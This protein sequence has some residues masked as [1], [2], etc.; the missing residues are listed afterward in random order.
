MSSKSKSKVR[1]P[2]QAIRCEGLCV[3]P[4]HSRQG[5]PSGTTTG[6][7][8]HET[9]RAQFAGKRSAT[10][11]AERAG[12]QH[13]D[14]DFDLEE[15]YRNTKKQ[16]K[17]DLLN[18]CYLGT[19]LPKMLQQSNR[20]RDHDPAAPEVRVARDGSLTITGDECGD[21]FNYH[22]VTYKAPEGVLRAISSDKWRNLRVCAYQYATR[23]SIDIHDHLDVDEISVDMIASAIAQR[24]TG[25][26]PDDF[27]STTAQRWVI[28]Q[29]SRPAP[30]QSNNANANPDN[31][32]VAPVSA[33]G[34]GDS[35][36][37]LTPSL[38]ISPPTDLRAQAID[39]LVACA[40]IML[41]SCLVELE[42]VQQ[43]RIA[44]ALEDLR[45]ERL[46]ARYNTCVHLVTNATLDQHAYEQ[47]RSTLTSHLKTWLHINSP[48]A[49]EALLTTL[50]S[51]RSDDD[52]LRTA[53]LGRLQLFARAFCLVGSAL[54][55]IEMSEQRLLSSNVDLLD[56]VGVVAGAANIQPNVPITLHT[57]AH[58]S[59][60][61]APFAATNPP[62]AVEPTTHR[63]TA[64]VYIDCNEDDSAEDEPAPRGDVAYSL[65]AFS[66]GR[67]VPQCDSACSD[68]TEPQPEVR[69]GYWSGTHREAL[70]VHTDLPKGADSSVPTKPDPIYIG[71]EECR[72]S[73]PPTKVSVENSLFAGCSVRTT[74][75]DPTNQAFFHT[76]IEPSID[77]TY[78]AMCGIGIREYDPDSK[79]ASVHQAIVTIDVLRCRDIKLID[80]F[81][82]NLNNND[83]IAHSLRHIHWHLPIRN[84]A[85][86]I[87]TS[88]RSNITHVT[89][90]IAPIL[91]P[92]AGIWN[93]L[94]SVDDVYA[95]QLPRSD[96]L[97]TTLAEAID[98]DTHMVAIHDLCVLQS[99][100]TY[101]TTHRVM[102]YYPPQMLGHSV[103]H[104]TTVVYELPEEVIDFIAGAYR[105]HIETRNATFTRP[106]LEEV[107]PGHFV[108]GRIGHD[109]MVAVHHKDS[110][111]LGKHLLRRWPFQL[112]QRWTGN[113]CACTRLI[114]LRWNAVL[115]PHES[116]QPHRLRPELRQFTNQFFSAHSDE[117]VIN[118]RLSA[119]CNAANEQQITTTATERKEIKEIL[120][121]EARELENT[122]ATTL[123]RP[124]DYYGNHVTMERVRLLNRVAGRCEA[125]CVT[126]RGRSHECGHNHNCPFGHGPLMRELQ[127]GERVE[128]C[129]V[130]HNVMRIVDIIYT[131]EWELSAVVEGTFPVRAFGVPHR[132]ANKKG[133]VA[134]A[135]RL[136][137]HGP[138]VTL[139]LFPYVPKPRYGPFL[140]G[141]AFVQISPFAT[142]IYPPTM[143]SMLRA[144]MLSEQ[145]R[146]ARFAIDFVVAHTHTIA[147]PKE[148]RPLSRDAWI[149]RFDG[150]KRRM[151]IE[152]MKTFD[153]APA[154][155]RK[156]LTR[157]IFKKEEKLVKSK[158]DQYAGRG[159]SSA[160]PRVQC[161]TGPWF[162]AFNTAL[163]K[164]WPLHGSKISFVCGYDAVAV[165]AM[166]TE[167]EGDGYSYIWDG[168]YSSFDASENM[169]LLRDVEQLVYR[170]SGIGDRNFWRC[171]EA[172]LDTKALVFLGR[173]VIAKFR[174]EGRRNSG[175]A[176][177]TIGNSLINALV[178]SSIL[179]FW[180]YDYRLAVSGD[181]CAI[182]FRGRHPRWE[183]VRDHAADCGLKLKIFPRTHYHDVHFLGSHPL[184]MEVDGRVQYV[185]VPEMVRVLPKFGWSLSPMLQPQVW[186]R[187]VAK[188]WQMVGSHVPILRSLIARTLQLTE[189]F[190]VM[191]LDPRDIPQFLRVESQ[192]R[193][194]LTHQGAQQFSMRYSLTLDAIARIE[195]LVMVSS[196]PSIVSTTLLNHV[197]VPE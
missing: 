127:N 50:P 105:T 122:H 100:H 27:D 163:K 191:K 183:D 130:C 137:G 169:W 9:N 34:A 91:L 86:A 87:F 185:M 45:R 134:T 167:W 112:K 110:C 188:S 177:T 144:R 64:L 121:M 152:A 106:Q 19:T 180:R 41:G 6:V 103:A 46:D 43:Q 25:I 189:G 113:S 30:Q 53:A 115:G 99:R 107:V 98:L 179:E 29:D 11:S 101:G 109:L 66:A 90:G 138:S 165:G 160:Q 194:H 176:N 141:I 93:R 172:Q 193:L 94:L 55:A 7:F 77:P 52:D 48:S 61:D 15:L 57:F 135:P 170:L 56:P 102:R 88:I 70:V 140:Y 124:N 2:A 44:A 96:L 69:V 5:K 49:R 83:C 132:D 108:P 143:H 159:I 28:K 8:R 92:R 126:F 158:F 182:A 186:N 84:A 150:S 18:A 37:N 142:S 79:C 196:L 148:I 71:A 62:R 139:Q 51:V 104:V 119:V 123:T 118:Q 168:D 97:E 72:T 16:A 155:N 26:T 171:M 76:D 117:C 38:T 133:A 31:R 40:S 166:F 35:T 197:L 59:T 33:T 174:C 157:K 24:K 147:W 12:P 78:M 151:Y 85:W 129:G 95:V 21:L 161:A 125:C 114:P 136:E 120:L 82:C 3:T 20:R 190:G 195:Q 13:T 1:G 178:I 131:G 42:S 162:A 39:A 58:I 116:A 10:A 67:E 32:R 74:Q 156:D 47:Y 128:Y 89:H 60:T 187:S 184:Q 164:L 81:T 54:G 192:H 181:D 145:F 65:Y 175:D 173:D 111:P 149:N 153:H 23:R 14:E 146:P 36:A 68:P 4:K 22:N 63:N 80:L 154:I 75:H 73:Y 17:R